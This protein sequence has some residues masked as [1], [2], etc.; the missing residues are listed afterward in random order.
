MGRLVYLSRIK[1]ENFRNFS[2]LD[3]ELCGNV[4]V[5]GENRVGKTNLLYA[6]RLLFDPTLPDSARQLSITDYWDGV[7]QPAAEDTITVLVEIK[8]FEDNLDINALLTDF[9]LDNDPNIARLTYQF[10]PRADLAADPTND[11]DFEFVTFGGEDEAKRFGHDL[12]RRICMDLLPALRDAEGDLAAWR[13]SPLRPLIEKA[14]NGINTEDLVEIGE[15]IETAT[16]KMGD[17]AEVRDLVEQ[18]RSLFLSMSGPKQDAKPTLGF[19]PTD[20][21]RLHR[22]IRLLID[23]G[24]RTISE[25]SLGSANLIFLTLKT[26]EL[27]N[28]IDEK[29][30]NHSFLAIEEPEAHLHP[31]LQR[32][33]YRHLFQR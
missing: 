20:V 2:E 11:N 19:S 9:R 21:G 24:L 16:A 15:S 28:L 22:S 4:V 14:F 32:S 5:V 25:A 17:F 13:R 30:R 3:V 6:L 33:V 29:R 23:D 7:G 27:Q 18:I 10:R 1:I 31:H 12:R 8:D 26:L